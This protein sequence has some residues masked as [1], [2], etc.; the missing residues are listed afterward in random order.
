M[1]KQILLLLLTTFTMFSQQ[2]KIPNYYEFEREGKFGK[3]NYKGQ[4]V[5]PAIY[6]SFGQDENGY[7]PAQLNGKYGVIDRNNKVIIPFK[8]DYVDHMKNDLVRVQLNEK[9]GWI[10]LKNKVVIPIIYDSITLLNDGTFIASKNEKTGLIDKNG[11]V[12]IDFKYSTFGIGDAI[13]EIGYSENKI[14]FEKDGKSGFLDRQQKEIIAPKF[15]GAYSFHNNYAIAI[16]DK[17]YGIIDQSGKFVIDPTF[18]NIYYYKGFYETVK[19]KKKG[20]LNSDLKEI[21]PTEYYEVEDFSEGLAV[22][23]KDKKFG[24]I[25]QN[26]EFVIPLIYD[27]AHECTEGLIAVLKDG[28]WGFVDPTNKTIID[29][30]FTGNVWPFKNGVAYYNKR[31]FSS[32]GKYNDEIVGLIDKKGE[33][34]LAPK[35]KEIGYLKNDGCLIAQKDGK[36]YLINLKGEEI[37]QLKDT[38]LVPTINS[39]N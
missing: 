27:G 6:D 31:G 28:Y 8:Y 9:Y 22:V 19:N 34:I 3:V 11:K 13:Q 20:Y 4:I 7:F 32:M 26:G 1:K 14:V 35:Y 29:F 16:V 33:I 21:L 15:D 2:F 18:T 36:D 10:N 30:K 5:I 24:L 39:L 38:E 25:N 37:F 23:E 12:I 17:L